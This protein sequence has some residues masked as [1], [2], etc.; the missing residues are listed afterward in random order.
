MGKPIGGGQQ[1]GAA[2]AAVP[3]AG[4]NGKRLGLVTHYFPKVNAA[5]IKLE[6]DGLKVGERIR[7]KGATTDLEFDISSLQIDRKPVESAEKGQHIGLSVS[8][9]VRC[10]DE[11]Y[12][13]SPTE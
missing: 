5:V 7:I 6:N 8:E 1:T 2:S 3:S 10:R 13:I 4:V 9:R 12:K 11:V